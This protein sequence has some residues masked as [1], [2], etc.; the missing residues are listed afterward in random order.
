MKHLVILGSTG[1]VGVNTLD[2]VARFPERFRVVGLAAGG[3]VARMERQARRFRPQVVALADEKAAATLS[4]K[5]SPLGIEVLAG[6]QGVIDVARQVA[7]DRVVSAIVGG[8]GLAP[9]WAAIHAGR[10]IA[11]AN[12][13]TMVMAGA[14]M[15]AAARKQGVPILPVD[16][17]H[18]GLFQ[19]MTGA[20]RAEVARVILTASGGP[21]IDFSA[22]M[23]RQVTPKQA[24]AHP[25]WKM[26]PKISIDSATLMNKGLEVIEA[27]WL[28]DLAPEQ[29]D[30]VI[31]RQSI[32]HAMIEFQDRSTVAQMALPD[33][34]V[35]ISYALFHPERAPMALPS[36]R[37]EKMKP[38]TFEPCRRQAFPLLG[39]AYAA[40]AAGGTAPA[41]LNG[42]NE[43][44]VAAFLAGQIGF[45]K[46]QAIVRKTLDAHTVREVKA[47]DDA[48]D[49]DAWARDTA[50]RLMG[51]SSSKPSTQKPRHSPTSSCG[52][53]R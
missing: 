11:L 1:S 41:A 39:A 47:I 52:H 8:A 4:R 28:F 35:P 30:V 26:G 17:E 29:I 18:S 19:V 34:R 37:L 51:T 23:K 32:I 21:L 33:M 14:L 25:T 22:A 31:H 40:L 24:L 48:L 36:L 12:K 45:M 46:M 16:S 20:R 43:E 7:A 42:A 44:A 3:D 6:A 49:A 9:T 2:V 10:A 27:R 53:I 50:R 38:L 13:E 5:L 15:M